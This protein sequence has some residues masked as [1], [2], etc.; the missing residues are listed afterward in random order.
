MM[1]TVYISLSSQQKLLPPPRLQGSGDITQVHLRAS[2]YLI[3]LARKTMDLGGGK[4]IVRV[5]R[6]HQTIC[7]SPLPSDDCLRTSTSYLLAAFPLYTAHSDYEI[8]QTSTIARICC[9]I[10][11]RF[12]HL[13][14][15]GP[16]I[17][18]TDD[19]ACTIRED[20]LLLFIAAVITTAIK[21]QIWVL[22]PHEMRG[23]H[24]VM[25]FLLSL[26]PELSGTWGSMTGGE[27]FVIKGLIRRE[28]SSAV[29]TCKLADKVQ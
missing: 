8:S 29:I 5:Q 7:R 21:H 3:T 10:Q 18:V 9:A 12:T 25:P 4:S 28:Q 27:Q 20:V 26:S 15:S 17:C 11:E 19:N 2:K 16:H 6:N 13:V 22:V 1:L 24:D 23:C 14:S